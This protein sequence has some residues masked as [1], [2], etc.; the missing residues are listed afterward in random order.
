MFRKLMLAATVL[1][2]PLGTAA[3]TDSPVEAG[4]DI[5]VE[6]HNT[7]SQTITVDWGD[8]KVKVKGGTWKKIGSSAVSIA[9][10]DTKTEDF[11]ATFNCGAKRR[12]KIKSTEGSSSKT[13][14]HPG[15]SSWTTAQTVHVHVNH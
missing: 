8:S 6:V 9:A 10:G 14:Y 11:K 2:L 13:T 4:C 15:T 12:Y 3:L 7:G 1:T 5:N